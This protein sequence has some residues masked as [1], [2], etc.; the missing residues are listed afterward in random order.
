[1]DVPPDTPVSGRRSTKSIK[2]IKSAKK[3]K[4]IPMETVGIGYACFD[5][6]NFASSESYEFDNLF[7]L[8]P[9]EYPNCHGCYI[10][11]CDCFPNTIYIKLHIFTSEPLLTPEFLL[12]TTHLSITV[13][14]IYNLLEKMKDPEMNTTIGFL[15]PVKD[16]EEDTVIFNKPIV[17]SGGQLV[18][19]EDLPLYKSWHHTTTMLGK[20]GRIGDLIHKQF[21]DV[22]D[23]FNVD[24]DDFDDVY[25]FNAKYRSI[26]TPASLQFMRTEIESNHMCAIEMMINEHQ[27]DSKKKAKEPK[28]DRYL[29][30]LDWSPLVYYGGKIIIYFLKFSYQY[31]I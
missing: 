1:M 13:E 10:C 30:I 7:Y 2:S 17:F 29:G 3:P 14:C 26:L 4:E 21:D 18:K 27:T 31:T 6:I 5:L 23:Q 16:E 9:P 28:G 20:G 11:D 25:S 15:Y 19:Y 24:I 8:D 12:D 22:Y